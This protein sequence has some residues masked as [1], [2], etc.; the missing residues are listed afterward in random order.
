MSVPVK[1]RDQLAGGLVLT[2]GLDGCLWI[3]SLEEW[4]KIADQVANMPVT[5]KNAR[6]FARFILSGAMDMKT[7][8]AGRINLPKY[9]VDYAGIKSK[10]IVAG[11]YNRLELWSEAKWNE[12]KQ[13]MEAN[14][15]EVA[16][17]LSEI[18][19]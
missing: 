12:F 17:T 5:Q 1:F 13:G 8:R 6:S 18:G 11:M 14:S 7:D 19:F 15:E 4:Q 9:L 10:V 16:E 2:R 3:Y